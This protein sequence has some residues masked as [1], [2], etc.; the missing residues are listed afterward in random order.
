MKPKAKGF[1]ETGIVARQKARQ[2][3]FMLNYRRQ[4]MR[5]KCK[6]KQKKNNKKLQN[7]KMKNKIWNFINNK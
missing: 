5:L 4:A 1:V 6:Y 3:H 7:R 2:A